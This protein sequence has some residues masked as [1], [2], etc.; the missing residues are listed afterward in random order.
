MLCLECPVE[1]G[2]L[3]DDLHG[4]YDAE[5]SAQNTLTKCISLSQFTVAMTTR[6][7]VELEI[8]ITQYVCVCVVAVNLRTVNE[9]KLV[10]NNYY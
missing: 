10:C 4:E 9:Y 8:N 5:Q 2:P 3:Q 6:K 7:Q 1:P